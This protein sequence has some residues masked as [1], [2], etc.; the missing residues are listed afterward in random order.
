MALR[1]NQPLTEM[2]IAGISWG[3]HMCII[4]SM[5]KK[6]LLGQGLLTVKTCYHTQSKH[7]ILRRIPLDE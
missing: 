7:N 2:N 1:S 6:P 4:L 3:V 5:A